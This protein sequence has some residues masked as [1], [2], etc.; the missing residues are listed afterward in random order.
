MERVSALSEAVQRCIPCGMAGAGCSSASAVQC[1]QGYLLR[2]TQCRRRQHR[3]V[4][5]AARRGAVS[6]A[7]V[8]RIAPEAVLRKQIAHEWDVLKAAMRRPLTDQYRDFLE[9]QAQLG[10]VRALRELRR[11]QPTRRT[12]DE[13]ERPGI[14]FGASHRVSASEP[15]SSIAG[16]SSRIMC[17]KTATSTTSAMVRR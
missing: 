1:D 5:G 15:K 9:E 6:V 7:R 16:R 12:G 14:A 4:A 13:R 3:H 17:R 2:E 10:N 11:M 8:E